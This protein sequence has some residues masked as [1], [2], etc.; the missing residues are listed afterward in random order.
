MLGRLVCIHP[1]SVMAVWRFGREL[2]PFE[3][4]DLECCRSCPGLLCAIQ[5]IEMKVDGTLKSGIE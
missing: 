4:R 3:I 1:S 5:R 2:V